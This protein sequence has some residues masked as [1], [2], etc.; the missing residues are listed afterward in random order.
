MVP[1]RNVILL[2]WIILGRLIS[3]TQTSEPLINQSTQNQI[4]AI[5]IFILFYFKKTQKI[6]ICPTQDIKI[7]KFVNS[8]TILVHNMHKAVAE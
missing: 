4:D 7:S 1:L 3:T 8:R 2:V 6:V 5:F